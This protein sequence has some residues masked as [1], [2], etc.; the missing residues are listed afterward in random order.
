MRTKLTSTLDRARAT[1]TEFTAGQKA[2]AIVGGGALLIAAFLVFRWVAAPTYAPLYSGL[3]GADASA[4]IDELET[5]GVSYKITGNGSTVMVPRADVYSTRIAL[6]GKG[7]PASNDGGYSILDDSS[8]STSEFKEQT[9]FK[10]AM[11]GELSKTIE[12]IDGIQTA[13]VHLAMPEK[14]VF[15]D[16][17]DP[18]TASVLVD[19]KT[20]VTLGDEQVQA[21][22]NLVASSI[23]GLDPK[24]VTVADASGKVL[25]SPNDDAN[26]VASTRAK[27]VEQYQSSVQAKIQALMDTVVGPGNSSTVVTAQLDFDK[28]VTETNE[29]LQPAD[30]APPLTSSETSEVY[31]GDPG[32]VDETGGVVGADGDMGTDTTAGDGS[33]SNRSLTLDNPYG[34]RNERRESAAGALQQQNISVAVDATAA[35]AIQPEAIKAMISSAVGIKPRRGDT[36]E[37]TVVPFDRSAADAAADALAKAEAEDA[38]AAR[39]EML[40]NIGIA[41]FIALA[42]LLAWFQARRRA[43]ARAEATEYLVEQIKADQAARAI[44]TAPAVA[45]L[46]VAEETE[47]DRIRDELLDLVDKQPADVAALLRGWLVEPRS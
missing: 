7:L 31:S 44:E 4:V 29:Y 12:A 2:V 15:T 23:D 43:A 36:V 45:A 42:I 16:T 46:E 25:S 33:Y 27:A 13:V 3:S 6:S 14:E 1:F 8:L 18:V 11:E 24:R 20:G 5:E 39:M 38:Q 9:D 30:D 47:E 22:V 37:V 40:R 32:A 28:A 41:G 19:T 34:T 10:R 26:G 21:I 35:A 17:Q